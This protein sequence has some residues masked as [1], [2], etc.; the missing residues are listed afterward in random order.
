VVL[1]FTEPHEL[2]PR[3]LPEPAPEAQASR[4][5]LQVQGGT[6]RARDREARVLLVRPLV[7]GE[8]NVA[9]RPEDF[10]LAECRG[11]QLGERMHRISDVSDVALLVRVPVVAGIVFRQTSV[12]RERAAAESV[13]VRFGIADVATSLIA[14]SLA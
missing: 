11:E 14:V 9:V 8:P 1:Q 12:E 6:R 10:T 2:I 5:E 4:G 13:E 7:R 3:W